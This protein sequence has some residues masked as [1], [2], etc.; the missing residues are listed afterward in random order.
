MKNTIYLIKDETTNLV[1]VGMTKDLDQRITHI[2]KKEVGSNI[3]TILAIPFVPNL[4]SAFK[5]YHKGLNVET[6]Y[7]KN[8]WFDLSV[9]E[10]RRFLMRATIALEDGDHTHRWL[11]KYVEKSR[12]GIKKNDQLWFM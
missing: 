11:R 3:K 9:E 8:E 2:K 1:K 12:Q 7:C 4:E 6:D 10:A 5:W